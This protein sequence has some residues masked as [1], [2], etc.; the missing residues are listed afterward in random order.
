MD[1]INPLLLVQVNDHLGVGVRSEPMPSGFELLLQ[2]AVVVDLAVQDHRHVSSLVEQ[3]LIAVVDVDDRETA[4][5]EAN[6]RARIRSGGIGPA[7]DQRVAHSPDHGW[8]EGTRRANLPG[9]SAHL[10]AA[11]NVWQRGTSE[12]REAKCAS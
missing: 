1:E 9:D 7:V 8:I 2:L 6:A 10:S 4:D 3:R 5:S 12:S 11:V